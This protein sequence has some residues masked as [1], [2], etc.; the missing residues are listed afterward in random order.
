MRYLGGEIFNA[1]RR[2]IG[3]GQAHAQ[4]GNELMRVVDNGRLTL[5]VPVALR[6]SCPT[7]GVGL[8]GMDAGRRPDCGNGQPSIKPSAVSIGRHGEA[9]KITRIDEILPPAS[10]NCS[11]VRRV[12]AGV[13][14][15]R[16]Y[17]S[18]ASPSP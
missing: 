16:S 11:A 12:P 13:A 2:R 4:N 3:G 10:R 8:S 6:P 1:G 5:I 7:E 9:S 15:C 14:V 17:T 18:V